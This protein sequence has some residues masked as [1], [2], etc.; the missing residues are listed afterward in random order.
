[1][2]VFN[3]PVPPE[4]S[5]VTGVT[6]W[7]LDTSLTCWDFSRCY[8]SFND[9]MDCR[10]W[11]SK[12]FSL[13]IKYFGL[14]CFFIYVLHWT[15]VASSASALVREQYEYLQIGSGKWGCLWVWALVSLPSPKREI[16][17]KSTRQIACKQSKER[18]WVLGLQRWSL[19]IRTKVISHWERELGCSAGCSVMLFQT[20]TRLLHCKCTGVLLLISLLAKKLC[21]VFF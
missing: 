1:M 4:G 9:L 6:F 18:K 16:K 19:L 14:A 2:W 13:S 10:W 21:F 15:R 11:N 12:I 20:F 7:L 5:K 17:S 8:E 3:V